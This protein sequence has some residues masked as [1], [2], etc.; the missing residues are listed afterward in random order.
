MTIKNHISSGGMVLQD[1]TLIH[2][3]FNTFV[4]DIKL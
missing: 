2:D 3:E 1:Y 4:A